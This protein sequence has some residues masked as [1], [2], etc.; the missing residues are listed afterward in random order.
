M[1]GGAH[2]SSNCTQEVSS[3]I[4][5]PVLSKAYEGWMAR[6]LKT[7]HDAQ[8][9]RED[10]FV[11]ALQSAVEDVQV[12]SLNSGLCLVSPLS[13]SALMPYRTPDVED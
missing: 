8:R 10:E 2:R 9:L 5:V 4:S 1:V 12:L 3:S 11:S 7:R 13:I 6:E